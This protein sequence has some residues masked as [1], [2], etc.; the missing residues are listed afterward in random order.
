MD[1]RLHLHKDELLCDFINSLQSKSKQEIALHRE[2]KQLR[3]HCKDTE[4]EMNILKD[5]NERLTNRSVF[6]ICT[7]SSIHRGVYGTMVGCL[8]LSWRGL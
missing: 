3:Q 8:W 4:S 6:Y 7:L 5:A 2:I 1:G